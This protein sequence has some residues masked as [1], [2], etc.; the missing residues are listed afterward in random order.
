MA[1]RGVVDA[2]LRLTSEFR[3][4][5]GILG[6]G[7][8]LTWSRPVRPG[9]ELRVEIEIVET[10]LSRS[11]SGQGVV[12]VR[13]TTLNQHDET[14]QTFTPT[15]FVDRRRDRDAGLDF[16]P[17]AGVACAIVGQSEKEGENR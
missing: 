14:V 9:D 3:P 8:E 7:G 17:P 5:G 1:Y 4:A 2:A 11:H 16:S 15:L 12:K 10:R 6:A 13:V